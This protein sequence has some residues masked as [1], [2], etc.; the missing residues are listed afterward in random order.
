M[1]PFRVK[2]L[3]VNNFESQTK[4]YKA[5]AKFD[6]GLLTKFFFMIFFIY[7]KLYSTFYRITISY[8]VNKKFNSELTFS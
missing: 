6:P 8:L 3:H 7:L 4:I 1:S 2:V 5:N